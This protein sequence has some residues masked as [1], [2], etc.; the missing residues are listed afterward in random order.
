MR[1]AT[2]LALLLAAPALR[3]QSCTPDPN[4]PAAYYPL[5]VGD[6]WIYHAPATGAGP[7]AFVQRRVLRE[8]TVG[9]LTYAVDQVCVT[10]VAGGAR[11]CDPER[12]V[13]VA[14]GTV[15]VRMEGGEST[16][17]EGLDAPLGQNRSTPAPQT[18]ARQS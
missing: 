18:S 15:V 4:P 13:R 10:A 1:L 3:A 17:F 16:L 9:G 6:E 2:L 7:E 14:G 5:G 8:E 11:T 12:L